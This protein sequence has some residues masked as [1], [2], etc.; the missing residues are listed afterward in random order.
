MH[1]AWSWLASAYSCSCALS[2][3][4]GVVAP[5]PWTLMD[6]ACAC[7][8]CVY[9]CLNIYTSLRMTWEN[10][11][12]GWTRKGGSLRTTFNIAEKEV[13][14]QIW[15]IVIKYCEHFKKSI[16]WALFWN[17]GNIFNEIPVSWNWHMQTFFRLS[18]KIYQSKTLHLKQQQMH[19]F[20]NPCSCCLK[21][22]YILW[23]SFGPK[24]LLG[25]TYF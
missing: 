17:T 21:L 15:N 6:A 19:L 18:G 4:I 24:L 13:A 5:A 10:P 9:T 3:S 22:F 7:L 20:E 12:S 11:F 23:V 14:P 2:Q 1:L 8:F 25:R 16:L